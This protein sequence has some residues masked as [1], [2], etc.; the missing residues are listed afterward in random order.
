MSEQMILEKKTLNHPCDI[1]DGDGVPQNKTSKSTHCFDDK[2]VVSS[3]DL[4]YLQF[5]MSHL[6]VKRHKPN[7]TPLKHQVDTDDTVMCHK[8]A[9]K[10]R[11]TKMNDD[12]CQQNSSLMTTPHKQHHKSFPT[13]CCDIHYKISSNSNQSDLS[14]HSG[15][16]DLRMFFDEMGLEHGILFEG[17]SSN[18][19]SAMESVSTIDSF[20]S[21]SLCSNESHSAPPGLSSSEL[22]GQ[23]TSQTSVVE[24]NARIIKWLCTVRKASKSDNQ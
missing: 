15:S 5:N 8:S 14:H 3:D 20:C 16:T 9:Y 18:N 11:C 19:L 21:R 1:V 4:E 23:K 2:D 24:R 17:K 7:E 22:A 12:H 6:N 13:H 10:K